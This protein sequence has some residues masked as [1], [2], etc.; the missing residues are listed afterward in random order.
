MLLGASLWNQCLNRIV[1]STPH[2]DKIVFYSALH[3]ALRTPM[4]AF[5]AFPDVKFCLQSSPMLT[6]LS[7]L[8]APGQIPAGIIAEMPVVS[9]PLFLQTDSLL[10]LTTDSLLHAPYSY[11]FNGDSARTFRYLS[12]IRSRFTHERDGLPTADHGRVS[13]WLVWQMLGLYPLD[14]DH[15]LIQPPVFRDIRIRVEP[16]LFRIQT[17]FG[18]S[19]LPVIRKAVLNDKLIQP[20]IPIRKIKTGGRLRLVCF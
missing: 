6:A 12:N 10:F 14:P 18:D 17:K 8:V 11:L 3:R 1:V 9:K 2:Y 5:E 19:P 16:A 15:F 7:E 20:H 13:A 4:P